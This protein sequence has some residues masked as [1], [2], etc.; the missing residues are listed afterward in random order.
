MG[1]EKFT[2]HLQE[3]KADLKSQTD[4]LRLERIA[5]EQETAKIK[6]ET[7]FY[8]RSS[9]VLQLIMKHTDLIKETIETHGIT[10]ATDAETKNRVKKE[11]V[12]TMFKADHQLLVFGGNW[13]NAV[14][15]IF[16]AS[17][18]VGCVAQLTEVI[19][20]FVG[21]IVINLMCIGVYRCVADAKK[22]QIDQLIKGYLDE[23]IGTC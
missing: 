7:E 3:L 10:P 18:I 15:V 23:K 12:H 4:K 2:A 1:P 13:L 14:L 9:K 20:I 6:K 11:L 5:L 21:I 22:E 19:I 8:K 16:C 17:L